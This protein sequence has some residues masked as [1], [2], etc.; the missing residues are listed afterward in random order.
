MSRLVDK[1]PTD[2]EVEAYARAAYRC[3]VDYW[4]REHGV[5]GPL[6]E[7]LRHDLKSFWRGQARV[8][9]SFYAYRD[10]PVEVER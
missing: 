8:A 5:V 6:W 1:V 2:L 10:N 4:T 9:L 7:H 3:F